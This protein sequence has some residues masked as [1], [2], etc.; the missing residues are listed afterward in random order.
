MK[1][2]IYIKVHYG[3]DIKFYHK[4]S[5]HLCDIKII[6][7]IITHCEENQ[8]PYKCLVSN[9][10]SNKV[11]QGT[12]HILSVNQYKVTESTLSW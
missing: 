2:V 1:S 9:S 12:R 4:T 3:A 7:K 11:N 10:V 5:R 8:T 6:I